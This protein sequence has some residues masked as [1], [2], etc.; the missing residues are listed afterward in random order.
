MHTKLRSIGGA[1]VQFV[2]AVAG[3]GM[4]SA[5]APGSADVQ[6]GEPIVVENLS[7]F[8]VR[9]SRIEQ[10]IE[11]TTLEAALAKGNAEISELGSGAQVNQLQIENKGKL[12]IY[13]LAGTVV[14][15]GNQDRQI[16]QDF[17][18]ERGAKVAVD[19]FCVEQGRWAAKRAGHATGGKFA[20][21]KGLAASAVRRAAQYEADQSAVWNRVSEVNAAHKKSAPSGTLLA[22]LDDGDVARRRAQ[23]V[24][25]IDAGLRAAEGQAP[26]V[27]LAYAVDGQVRNVRWFQTASAFA[28][29]RSTLLES[30]ALDALTAQAGSGKRSAPKVEAAAV[31]RFVRDVESGAARTRDTAAQNRNEYREGK[32][33]FG[34]KTRLKS[35]PAS[36]VPVSSDY[37]AK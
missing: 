27:G 11:L 31:D 14:E 28:L 13:V 8:P 22:T 25:L 23:L 18:I 29:F 21:T 7:V 36:A 6:I 32:A 4:A 26:V 3:A 2:F 33:G 17:V 34:S 12:P 35:Q 19:A 16:A 5:T 37:T 15:G 1:F 10:A 30:A 9:T 24:R 20:K